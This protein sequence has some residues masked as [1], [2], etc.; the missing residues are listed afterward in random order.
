[1][2]RNKNLSIG[3]IYYKAFYDNL[4]KLLVKMLSKKK[5]NVIHLPVEEQ[6][7]LETIKSKTKNCKIIFNDAIWGSVTFEGIELSKTLEELGKKVVNSSHSFFYQEDKWMFY[8][9]CLEH[10]IPTPK[11]YIIPK[12][13]RYNSKYIK[14][15][16]K[17][18]K[19]IVLKSVFSDNG[20]CVERVSNFLMFK[21]KLNKILKKDPIT[22]TIAQ[23]CILNQKR[24]YRVTLINH[25]IQQAVV[26]IGKSWKQVGDGDKEY[27]R[28]IKVN[29]TLRKLCE[30]ASLAFGM[31]VCG[32]DLVYN[33]KWY[34]IET[35]GCPAMDFIG[36][37]IPRLTKILANYLYSECKKV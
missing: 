16:L 26:K 22:P 34:V 9:K 29:N 1:M 18:H 23:E 15:I 7:D 32:L 27:F 10:K 19:A 17:K 2:V 12:E 25:R 31:K 28:K 37:D 35:N 24:S 21:Y 4:D 3:F 33:G 14:D 13:L 36:S 8:L 6:I 5:L 11:T 20:D 30:R